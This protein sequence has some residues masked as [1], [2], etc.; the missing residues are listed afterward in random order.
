MRLKLDRDRSAPGRSRRPL[1]VSGEIETLTL[2]KRG[3]LNGQPLIV[4]GEI[5]TNL[6]GVVDLIY[7]PPLIV[8]GEIETRQSKT[9][10]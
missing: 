9:S 5:E 3:D 7:K 8:S 6:F 1:I 2:A 4:S 10:D